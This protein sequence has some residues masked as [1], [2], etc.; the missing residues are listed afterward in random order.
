MAK[1]I[2]S[3]LISCY[4]EILTLFNTTQVASTDGIE[5]FVIVK[6]AG[7][8][9]SVF[10][11]LKRIKKSIDILNKHSELKLDSISEKI[12]DWIEYLDEHY[13]SKSRWLKEPETLRE[14]DL[15]RLTKDLGKFEEKIYQIIEDSSISF[16]TS[17]K[18][19]IAS[20]QT[21]TLDK[22]S[23]EDLKEGIKA[24][25][26]GLTTAAYMLFFRVAESQVKSYYTKI[27]GTK[28]VGEKSNWGNMLHVLLVEHRSKVNKNLTN[29]LYY[30]KDKR[31]E[32]QHPGKRFKQNDCEKILHYLSDLLKEISK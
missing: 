27:T 32:A 3:E 17:K 26:L 10:P 22:S 7:E 12:E 20:N 13:S 16:P 23:K 31:N 2:S 25:D 19:Q 24:M 1:N 30:L 5:V 28:P 9:D 14:N 29:L 6:K 18:Q 11:S 21:K 15:K 4:S 8:S